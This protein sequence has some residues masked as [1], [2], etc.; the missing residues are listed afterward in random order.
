[1]TR[2]FGSRS[3]LLAGLDHAGSAAVFQLSLAITKWSQTASLPDGSEPQVRGP[4]QPACDIPSGSQ[5]F[6]RAR[7]MGALIRRFLPLYRTVV[8]L[9][10]EC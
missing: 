10:E 8:A 9:G 6:F 1:M 7:H 2:G 4:A 3:C 5:S